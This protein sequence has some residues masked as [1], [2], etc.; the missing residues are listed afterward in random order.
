LGCCRSSI[1]D[2][3]LDEPYGA[4]R[5]ARIKDVLV[6]GEPGDEVEDPER[7]AENVWR[8]LFADPGA[9]SA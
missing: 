5:R 3:I 9:D 4:M 6:F 2:E 7:A 1:V 8:S